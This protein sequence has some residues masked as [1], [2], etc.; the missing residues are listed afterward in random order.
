M[1]PLDFYLIHADD[2]MSEYSLNH[3]RHA[4]ED[5]KRGG[6]QDI[7]DSPNIFT[8]NSCSVEKTKKDFSFFNKVNTVNNNTIIVIGLYLEL[9]EFWGEGGKLVQIITD[10]SNKYPNNYVVGYWNHDHDFSRYNGTVINLKNLIILNHGYTSSK[11]DNDILLPFWNISENNYN[12]LKTQFCSF[13][14]TPNNGLR[15]QLVSEIK[16][17]NNNDIIHS[18]IRGEEYLKSLSRT[19]FSLCPL[20]GHGGGGFSYRVFESIQAN[21]IPVIIVDSLV[22]PM[23]DIIEW[24]DISIR[25]NQSEINN[26]SDIYNK[27]KSVDYNQK[28]SNLLY[29]KDKF[30]LL[31][32]QNYVYTKISNKLKNG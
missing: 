19:K 20:G 23:T 17:F 8:E 2:I 3:H 18:Q 25:I 11:T 32:V 16:N 1:K 7:F 30:N 13:I 4:L 29:N 9:L 24:D 12:E 14:G 27:L 31:G 6:R 10:I 28:L 5:Y 26:L 22:Y 21:S 15:N